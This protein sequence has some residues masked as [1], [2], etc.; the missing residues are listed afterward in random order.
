MDDYMTSMAM[1]RPKML[2]LWT[3]EDSTKIVNFLTINML[4][5]Q[6]YGLD[7]PHQNNRLHTKEELKQKEDELTEYFLEQMR[8][9]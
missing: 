1:D 9:S 7:F 2:R 8:K 4:K 5:A 6:K 3:W